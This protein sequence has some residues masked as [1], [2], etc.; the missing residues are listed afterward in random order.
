MITD[1]RLCA[2][3]ALSLLLAGPASAQP[4][5]RHWGT[6][7]FFIDAEPG[8]VAACLEA[9]A[10][11]NAR[12]DGDSHSD[13]GATPRHLA[14]K[15]IAHPGTIT[16]L[17]AAGADVHARDLRGA[18]PLH[19]AAGNYRNPRVI[20]ELVEAGA[21]VNARGNFWDERGGGSAGTGR[22]CTRPRGGIPPY[23]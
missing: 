13:G 8:T 5:C 9:G 16:V 1:K 2:F 12:T 22:R 23:S 14:L 15:Y 3:A 17:L 4:S 6:S 19:E 10:D 21:D 20:V 7:G 18:T 11:I